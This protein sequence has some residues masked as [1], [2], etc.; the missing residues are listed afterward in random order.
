MPPPVPPSIDDYRYAIQDHFD[1]TARQRG[2]DSGATCSSYASSTVPTWAA[3]AA[4][5]IAWRDQVWT[6]TYAELA[7]VEAGERAQ[8]SVNAFIGE[9]PAMVWPA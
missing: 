5:L 4:A 2:Y 1:A 3:Q 8:P 7:K 6:Y 9:L